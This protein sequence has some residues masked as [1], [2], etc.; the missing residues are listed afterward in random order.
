MGNSKMTLKS[1]SKADEVRNLPKTTIE[2]VTLG[3]STV[4]RATFLPGWKWSD[5][6][7]PTAQTDSCQVPHLNYII[8]GRMA[9]QMDDGSQKE[10]TV[11]DI[12]DIPPGH[13]AWVVGN[14]PCVM[15]DFSAGNTY[16]KS[17]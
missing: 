8:S 2:L 4:M 3:D 15:I 5:C 13:D 1:F 10:M 17:H 14:E 16:G 12:A 7:K 11:G 6:V 9:I